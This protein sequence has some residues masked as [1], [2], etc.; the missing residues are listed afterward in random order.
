MKYASDIKPPRSDGTHG[1]VSSSAGS[2]PWTT[3]PAA[4]WKPRFHKKSVKCVVVIHTHI[5]KSAQNK[6]GAALLQKKL[7]Q[8]L[9][10]EGFSAQRLTKVH[11]HIQT[12]KSC[13]R[14][15]VNGAG[16]AT[17]SSLKWERK[18]NHLGNQHTT[19]RLR[20]LG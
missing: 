20:Y 10:T 17:I 1:N 4:A 15:A 16:K 18:E 8:S 3:F 19:P 13:C 5:S 14:G 11:K 6:R 2:F 12:K 7:Q 9:P